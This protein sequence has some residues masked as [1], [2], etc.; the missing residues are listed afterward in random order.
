MF[1][2]KEK[3]N[4][5]QVVIKQIIYGKEIIRIDL[6]YLP[7]IDTGAKNRTE[8]L[9]LLDQLQMFCYSHEI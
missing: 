4:L 5:L 7:A 8:L 3:R 2:L 1:S 6:F 9:P